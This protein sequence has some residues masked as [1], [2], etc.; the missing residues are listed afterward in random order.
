MP[1]YKKIQIPILI[2]HT[3]NRRYRYRYQKTST[4]QTPP[5]NH[6]PVNQTQQTKPKKP[7]PVKLKL[8]KQTDQAHQPQQTNINNPDPANLIQ[9]T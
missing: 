1:G 6:F 8:T 3:D 5:W 2:F 9:Q 4:Q 7:N